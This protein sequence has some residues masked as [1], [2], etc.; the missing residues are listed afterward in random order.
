VQ[1]NP[2]EMTFEKSA[3]Y[4]EV[5]IPG[6]DAPLQQFVRNDGE[7]LTLELFFDS[8]EKGMGA[9]ARSVT[10]D[11]D[12]VYRLI[13]MDGGSHAPAVV[14]FSWNRSFP[15]SKITFP[16]SSSGP[17]GDLSR[18]SFTGVVQNIRQRFTLFSSEGVPLRATVSLTLIEFRPLDLQLRELGLASPDR[19]HGHVLAAAETLSGV[20]AEY[21]G[22][23]HAWRDIA[24]ANG[25]LDPRRL[26]V[27]RQISV[28]AIT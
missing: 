12:K 19:A 16:Q 1:F 4:G 7:R 2:G 14:T 20:A 13:R 11:T 23:P 28:P 10:E 18:Y 22:Q 25:L 24:L 3:R 17:G 15:G 26:P 6:L 8:T 5:A 21:Y 9:S 27:G